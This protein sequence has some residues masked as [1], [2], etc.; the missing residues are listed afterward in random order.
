[1]VREVVVVSK[2][3][4][5]EMDVGKVHFQSCTDCCQVKVFFLTRQQ[6]LGNN[7]SQHFV[8]Q[9]VEKVDWS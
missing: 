1:M 4:W 6:H 3:G 7:I 5:G 9:T 2:V 8:S